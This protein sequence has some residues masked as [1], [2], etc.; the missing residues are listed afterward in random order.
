MKTLILLLTILLTGCAGMGDAFYK[1]G[2]H[3]KIHETD[4]KMSVDCNSGINAHVQL[5]FEVREIPGLSYGLGHTSDI[6]CGRPFSNNMEYTS[7]Q[8]FVEYKGYFK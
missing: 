4:I 1:V 8:L 6:K 2:L 7:E 5:G 3:R